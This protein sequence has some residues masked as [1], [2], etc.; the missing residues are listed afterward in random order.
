MQFSIHTTDLNILRKAV[1]GLS[2]EEIGKEM[3]LPSKDIAKSLKTLLDTT[4]SKDAF[5]AMQALAKH[6]FT[7]IDFHA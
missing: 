1:N 2:V 5:N 7:V 6:G 3:G 4:K